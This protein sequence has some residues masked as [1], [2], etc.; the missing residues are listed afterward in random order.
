MGTK[1]FLKYVK[2]TVGWL[3]CFFGCVL[4]IFFFVPLKFNY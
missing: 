3:V 4:F 1:E 2:K